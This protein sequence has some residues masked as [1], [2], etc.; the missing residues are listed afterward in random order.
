MDSPMHARQILYIC[1]KKFIIQYTNI[2]KE[3]QKDLVN[4]TLLD[5]IHKKGYQIKKLHYNFLNKDDLLKMN[6]KYLNHKEH[7]DI[8]SF[9]YS[10]DLFLE[11]E[12]FISMWAVK[13]SSQKFSQSLEKEL[14]R[15][16]IHGVLHCMGYKDDTQNEIRL[17]RQLE[18]NF[19][20]MFHVK[21]NNYV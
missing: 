14:L 21:Q 3:L 9:D 15:V 19:I 17:M 7:T 5:F 18:D 2:P 20:S 12:F 10:D 16:L 6:I 8:I 11:A 4:E 13:K 1:K